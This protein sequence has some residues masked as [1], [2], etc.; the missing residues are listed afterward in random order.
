[1][2]LTW[3]IA[4]SMTGILALAGAVQAQEL[5]MTC[6]S[7]GNECEVLDDLLK[8]FTKKN[9]G[10]SVKIDTVPYKAILE[11]LPIQLAGGSGPDL[12]R[13][14]DLGGLS[15]YYLDLSPYIDKAYWEKNFGDTQPWYRQGP[16]DKGVYG[17]MTQLTITGGFANK[18][19]FEQANVPLPGPKATWDEW[20]EATRKVAKATDTPFPMAIDRSGHRIAGPA[21]SYGAKFFNAA[22]SPKVVDPGF[23]EFAKRLINWHKDGTFAKDV[24]ASKGGSTYQ[25]AAQEFS[26]GKLVYYYSGSWQIGRFEQAVGD[27]FDWVAVGSPCGPTAC[28]GMPGG[29]GLVGFKQTKHPEAVGKVMS[30]LAQ[31]DV[32][33]ELMVRTRNLTAHKELAAKGIEYPD[34]KKPTAAALK[35]FTEASTQ[36]SPV[37]Y[38]YQGYRYNRAMFNASVARL[39]QAIVGELSLDDA[40]ARIDRDVDEAVKA[41]GKQ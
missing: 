5:R 41:A 16:D 12:A 22:G 24:W 18:T 20:A 7:D 33:K 3:L 4:G 23:T 11:S 28:S 15:R 8:E 36:V 6:S 29:S 1:M 40:L 26:N 14:T 21:A 17:L 34:A 27:A 38:A 2:K 37:A 25:D 9:A 39:T 30:Y 19:L 35:A 10:I 31:P 32:H 13:L